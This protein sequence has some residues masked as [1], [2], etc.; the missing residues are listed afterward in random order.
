[1]NGYHRAVGV[2]SLGLLALTLAVA[3]RGLAGQP[4]ADPEAKPAVK[5]STVRT[6]YLPDTPERYADIDLPAHFRTAA[7]RR[8]DNTPPDNPVTDHGATLG[9]VLFYDTR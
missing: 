7:A 3:G 6:L 5:P 4:L 1:M 2:V 8:F 9:R